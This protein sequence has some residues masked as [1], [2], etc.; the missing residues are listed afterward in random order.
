MTRY[1]III[2]IFFFYS[3]TNDKIETES[4]WN[5]LHLHGKVKSILT[6]EVDLL[7]EN[8]SIGF[9]LTEFNRNGYIVKEEIVNPLDSIIRTFHY[10]DRSILDSTL[11]KNFSSN[12]SLTI[13]AYS[14]TL[15]SDKYKNLPKVT[16]EHYYYDSTGYLIK[17]IGLAEN[18]DTLKIN[19]FTFYSYGDYELNE[20]YFP[21]RKFRNEVINKYNKNKQI[22]S[23]SFKYGFYYQYFYDSNNLLNGYKIFRSTPVEEPIGKIDSIVYSFDERSNWIQTIHYDSGRAVKKIIREIEYFWI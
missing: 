16:I 21:Q 6:Y 11:S 22:K 18:Y 15:G 13:Y 10:N 23:K 8:D 12:E 7:N 1:L 20:I 9:N 17:T 14:D 4:D 5:K 3:C 2:I 19:K